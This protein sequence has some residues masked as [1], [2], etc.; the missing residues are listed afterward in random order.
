MSINDRAILDRLWLPDLYSLYAPIRQAV[1]SQRDSSRYFANSKTASY[2]DVTVPNFAFVV[3]P[4]GQIR[5]STRLPPPPP[6]PLP[7]AHLSTWRGIVKDRAQ[8]ELH[9][10]PQVLPLRRPALHR[11]NNAL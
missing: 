6:P 8:D 10:G 9:D 2:N 7:M 5:Y 4:D 1:G 11:Q 3:C